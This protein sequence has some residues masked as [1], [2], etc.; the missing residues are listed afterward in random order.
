MPSWSPTAG[1][2]RATAGYVRWHNERC[3]ARPYVNQVPGVSAEPRPSEL[4]A[5]S[6]ACPCTSSVGSLV[7]RP[8]WAPV[9][10]Q[11][12]AHAADQR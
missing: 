10:F 7:L 3:P 11:N 8:I 9:G 2:T 5:T 12:V 1:P 4:S 6:R